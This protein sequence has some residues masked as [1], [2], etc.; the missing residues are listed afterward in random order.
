[1]AVEREDRRSH[2]DA[3]YAAKAPQEVSWYQVAPV[4]SLELIARAGKG[5]L[6]RIIDVG[7]GASTLVDGLLDAGHRRVTVL[8]ISARALA[9]ARGRLGAR[10]ADVTWLEADVTRWTPGQAFDVWHDR[11]VFHFLVGPEDRRDYLEA[12]T[13]AL[14]P[15]GQ[16]VIGTFAADGPDRCSGLPV[17]RYEPETLAKELGDDYRLLDSAHEDH[18]TPSGKLQR[19]QFSRFARA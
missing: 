10:A 9:R 4:T 6:A 19:F 3:L 2:W 1:V 5:P 7:G 14:A 17:R 11:A 16:A 13:L 8:D 15:G 12:M 18:R